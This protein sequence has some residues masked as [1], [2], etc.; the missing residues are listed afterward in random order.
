MRKE[1]EKSKI[2]SEGIVV[3][4]NRVPVE[5]R[6]VERMVGMGYDGGRVRKEVE[7]NRHNGIT[8]A[9]YLLLKKLEK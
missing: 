4:C 3:G 9:Y 8:A 2:I 6:V 5:G 7:A 1:K